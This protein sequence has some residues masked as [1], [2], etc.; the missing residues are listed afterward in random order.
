MVSH[1][2]QII[3]VAAPQSRN[4]QGDVGEELVKGGWIVDREWEPP[5][6]EVLERQVFAGV[7]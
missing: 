2:H 1:R 7:Y 5:L 6:P 3:E 4:V